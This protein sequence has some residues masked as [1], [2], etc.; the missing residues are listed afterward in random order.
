MT[1]LTDTQLVL[2]SAASQH[3]DGVIPISERL[4]GGVAKTVGEK[5]I[6]LGLAEERHA[7][8]PKKRTGWQENAE[9]TGDGVDGMAALA[10]PGAGA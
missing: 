2:L 7:V 10:D 1:K 3:A 8:P 4:K 6:A 9:G 5:L